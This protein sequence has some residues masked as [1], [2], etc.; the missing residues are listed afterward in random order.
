MEDNDRAAAPPEFEAFEAAQRWEPEVTDAPDPAPTPAPPKPGPE[1][2]FVPALEP[3]P[4][5][6][7]ENRRK[8]VR[9]KTN[10]KPWKWSFRFVEELLT[11]RCVSRG[12]RRFRSRN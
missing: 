3:K 4:A 5:A 1:P 7:A 11:R 10:F 9:A 2:E 12:W 6:L 8:H